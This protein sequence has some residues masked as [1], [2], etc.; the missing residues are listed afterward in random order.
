MLMKLTLG[1][2]FTN[3]LRAA[4][5]PIFFPPKKLQTQSVS[6]Q[7]L[8]KMLMYEKVAHKMLVTLSFGVN[9]INKFTRSSYNCIFSTAQPLFRQ[10]FLLAWQIYDISVQNLN[11]LRLLLYTKKWPKSRMK[12]L[13]KLT[14][15]DD[16]KWQKNR[17]NLKSVLITPMFTTLSAN[18][19]L[20]LNIV[21]ICF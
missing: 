2:N 17:S 4:F 3:I 1:V 14:L 6:K 19:S 8:P 18:G 16:W 11:I 12:M 7:K 5:S 15:N 21:M 20:L 13:M 9:F 10:P